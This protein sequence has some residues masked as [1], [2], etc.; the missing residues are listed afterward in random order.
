MLI[1]ALEFDLVQKSDKGPVDDFG[2]RFIGLFKSWDGCIV[3]FWMHDKG[4]AYQIDG[5]FD[6]RVKRLAFRSP[7]GAFNF[8]KKIAINT[9]GPFNTLEELQNG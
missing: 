2:I 8:C 1:K 7:G 5:A 6:K 3:K 9:Y 4:W